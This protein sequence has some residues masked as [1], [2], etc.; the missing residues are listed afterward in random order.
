[1][2]D[3]V[4]ALLRGLVPNLPPLPGDTLPDRVIDLAS[5]R[6]SLAGAGLCE[7]IASDADIVSLYLNR[8]ECRLISPNALFDEPW[9]RAHHQDVAEAVAT[10]AFLCGFA[11][12]LSHG[13]SEG[14]WPNAPLMH[15]AS[16]IEMLPEAEAPVDAVRYL[17]RNPQA[18]LFLE[19]FPWMSAAEH[20]AVYGRR[21]GYRLGQAKRRRPT[22]AHA[23][24]VAGEFDARFYRERYLGQE[25]PECLVDEFE[26]YL[27][28][29]AAAGHDPVPWFE[30]DWYAAFYP[31]V[32]LAL[33]DGLIPS[34]FYHYVMYGRPEGRLP[35]FRL[36]DALEAKLPGVTRPALLERVPGL[37]ERLDVFHVRPTVDRSAARRPTIWFLLPVLNPDISFGGYQACFALMAAC[38]RDGFALG[39]I[40]LEEEASNRDYVLWRRPD[41]TS[42]DVFGSMT[43]IG[44]RTMSSLVIGPEDRFVSY[45]VWSL[46]FAEHLSRQAGARLPYLLAQEYE[47]IFYEN[48]ALRSLSEEFYRIAHHPIINSAFLKRYFEQNRVGIFRNGT[49][50]PGSF[51]VF[52]HRLNVSVPQTAVQIRGRTARTLAAYARPEAHAGRNLFE[53]VVLALEQLCSEGVFGPEW[54]FVGLG[55]LSDLPDVRLGPKHAMRLVKKMDEADYAA[56]TQSVDIGVSLMAA[57]HPSVVPFE[58][59]TT[60]ALVVTN[61]YE[62]RS[63]E[64]LV[65]ICGNIVPCAP[66]L[67]ALTE[68][69]RGALARVDDADARARDAFRPSAMRWEEIFSPAFIRDVFGA[70]VGEGPQP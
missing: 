19:A 68:A 7:Q 32:A 39:A 35:R 51:S 25:D 16:A 13:L 28:R 49:P 52:E 45:S 36:Q 11:H 58:L 42:Q 48:D 66:G 69:L 62:N 43:L 34:A 1:V 57:P 67:Q 44:R 46:H 40:C 65:A 53:L 47:P 2:S 29:G 22:G 27:E 23:D 31:D 63:A 60:G 12:F 59:A 18:R 70:P 37:R 21:L 24:A 6:T 30:S 8:A 15:A 56:F 14:R 41:A 64:D 33:R 26:H 54:S 4:L 38:R 9:Y 3:E 61:T 17:E 55:A 10:G 20:Y 5:L 50:P